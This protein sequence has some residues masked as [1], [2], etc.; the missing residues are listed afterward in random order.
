MSM[1]AYLLFV[2][3][4]VILVLV[5][6]PD[7][8]YMLTRTIA[9]G[10][11][12]GILAAFGINAGAYVHL[13]AAVA[14]LSALL[15]T[16]AT[17]FTIIKWMGAAY[18]FYLGVKAQLSRE[19]MTNLTT[20]ELDGKS[21]RAVFWQGF[22]SDVLNPKVAIFYV[23]LLPQFINA[24]VG[25][26]TGQ[27]ILLGVTGNVIAILINLALVAAAARLTH[28]LRRNERVA[29]WLQRAMGMLFIGLGAR[30]A[31]QET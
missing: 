23:A 21:L 19:T 5:P 6:G 12:A 16:S 13:T 28:K 31:A 29:L 27:L 18:L 17:A 2:V 30:V 7:M 25:N 1:Q 10:R 15:L 9:Q 20:S 26:A 8:A 22:W 24:E 14:G 11:R 3:A 4:S